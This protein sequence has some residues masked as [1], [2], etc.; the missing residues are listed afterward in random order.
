MAPA[1]KD[2][3]MGRGGKQNLTQMQN[4]QVLD[5]KSW[6]HGPTIENSLPAK[7]LNLFSYRLETSLLLAL[8]GGK[9]GGSKILGSKTPVFMLCSSLPKRNRLSL[10]K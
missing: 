4:K 1:E 8:H 9:E 7:L 2:A 5:Q 6:Q 10:R 3:Q